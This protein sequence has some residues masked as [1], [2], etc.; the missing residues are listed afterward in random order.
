MTVEIDFFGNQIPV[1]TISESLTS[2]AV[3]GA[4]QWLWLEPATLVAVFPSPLGWIAV[5]WRG[6]LLA[7]LSFGHETAAE[8]L[9]AILSG[10]R[11]ARLNPQEATVLSEHTELVRRLRRYAETFA[12]GDFRDVAIDEVGL[13]DFQ[14]QVIASCRSIPPGETRTY[15][16]LARQV[17][18][19]QAARAVGSVMARNRVPLVVPCHRVVG[20][21]GQLVGF[22]AP[23]GVNMK[24]RLLRGERDRA[25]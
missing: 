9:Q 10:S 22:S 3:S 8:A 18:S 2:Q 6:A 24:Q 23:Q 21:S 11:D 20:A 5:R 14:R 19:P 7:Q 25:S 12:D 16:E 13:T 1:V 17:G 4:E 15:G